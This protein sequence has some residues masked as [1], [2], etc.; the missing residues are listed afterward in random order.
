MAPGAVPSES[1]LC[2]HVVKVIKQ[3]AADTYRRLAGLSLRIW[4]VTFV[5]MHMSCVCL[6]SR[7][8]YQLAASDVVKEGKNSRSSGRMSRIGF[9]K[10]EIIYWPT[11]LI[12][13]ALIHQLF[14]CH[15]EVVW[16]LPTRTS[17]LAPGWPYDC[18]VLWGSMTQVETETERES[19][20][21]NSTRV[22]SV[23]IEWLLLVFNIKSEE[24]K[25]KQT[26]SLCI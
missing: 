19:K 6:G 1:Y 26:R 4:C 9:D 11:Y 15:R 22:L 21:V 20:A 12:C 2:F 17:I 5:E 13:V 3:P 23:G 10:R 8:G 24:I 25:C 14:F 16:H 18:N 7:V